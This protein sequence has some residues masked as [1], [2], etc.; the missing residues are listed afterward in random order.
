MSME[1]ESNKSKKVEWSKVTKS[2]WAKAIAWGLLFL[3]FSIWVGNIWFFVLVY[4]FVFDIY[5]TRFVPWRWWEKSKSSLL[6]GV[7]GLVEDLVVVLIIVHFLN[8]FLFQ[9]FK[10]PTGSLEKTA[11]IGDHLFVSKLSYGPRV[12]M[13][14]LAFPLFHNQFPGGGKSYID[15]PQWKYK[16]LK[17]LG[18]VEMYDI[19]VFNFPV[20]DTVALNVTNPDYY[21]L[22]KQYG[23]ERVWSDRATFGE[24][25]Y[26]PVDMRDHY[27]KRAVGMPGDS[28][29]IV[30]NALFINGQKMKD[31]ELLQYNYFVETNGNHF[32]ANELQELGINNDDIVLLQ[33]QIV[34]IGN[35][36]IG[37]SGTLYHFPLTEGMKD[38]LSRHSIVTKI[39]VEPSP[40]PE[41]F[42]TYPINLDN[43][44]T[45]D[46]YGPIWIPQKGA[47]ILLTP[48]N[49]A[50]YERC[51]R[52]YEKHDLNVKDGRVYID[53]IVSDTYTFEMDYYWMMGDNR[54]NSLD[55]RSWGF[56]PEDHIVGEPMFVWLSWDKD[57]GSVRWD[58]FFTTLQ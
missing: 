48:D 5:I 38:K 18:H 55:S 36:T 49:L 28:L 33:N 45:R 3:L 31:P 4:P 51:I 25:V 40:T 37:K 34:I 24:V 16:R 19:V 57:K 52:N 58:R 21:T 10:I 13:T 26:R 44:W 17:G 29:Q 39:Q 50:L 35:D 12:P 22:R 54:H 47:T 23:R 15:K 27:V 53:G 8:L 46:N 30:D 56:V 42:Y 14:P 41:Q 1:K 11:L 20:G 6:R 9:Q 7:M 2:N 32:S 43:G